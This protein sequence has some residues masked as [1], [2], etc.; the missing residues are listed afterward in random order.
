MSETGIGILLLLIGVLAMIG[1]ALNWRIVT[2]SGKLVNRLF[3]DT[4]ARV[5]Y[6]IAGFVLFIMGIGFLI[7][8]KWI[9]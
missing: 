8:A 3:G 4:A 1:S 5:I 6:F 9:P 7:G 2:R